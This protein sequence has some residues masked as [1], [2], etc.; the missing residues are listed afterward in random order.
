MA[1]ENEDDVDLQSAPFSIPAADKNPEIY[2]RAEK[3]K[4]SSGL[5]PTVENP[6]K[7]QEEREKIWEE[8]YLLDETQRLLEEEFEEDE[9]EDEGDVPGPDSPSYLQMVEKKADEVAGI[10]ANAGSIDA[11]QLSEL[12]AQYGI[13]AEYLAERAKQQ[14]PDF[15]VKN[16]LT[17]Y[18]TTAAGFVIPIIPIGEDYPGPRMMASNQPISYAST[19]TFENTAAIARGMTSIFNAAV[20]APSSS[21]DLTLEQILNP[22]APKFA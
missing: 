10:L 2:L 20:K 19:V 12:A 18:I 13:S 6:E 11:S 1:L 15:K 3:Y 9:L 7:Q 21:P 17:D 22:S 14:N 16:D 4:Q 8:Q 5:S